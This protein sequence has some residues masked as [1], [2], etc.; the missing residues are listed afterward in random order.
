MEPQ[1]EEIPQ[2]LDLCLRQGLA[3]VESGNRSRAVQLL[4]HV[5]TRDETNIAAWYGLSQVVDSL[6][7]KEIC[8]Q[9][10]IT[11]DPDDTS[12]RRE[13][14]TTSQR[15]TEQLLQQGILQ[16]K[17][18]RIAEARETFRQVAERDPANP[19]PW[20]WL[21]SLAETPAERE[22]CLRTL[23]ELDPYNELAHR[24]LAQ[25]EA[26]KLLQ[27]PGEPSLPIM[28]PP[29]PI[30]PPE[31]PPP[32][33]VQLQLEDRPIPT[34]P[35]ELPFWDR[36]RDELL[37]PYCAK[38][39]TKMED[40]V[41][42]VCQ[43]PL[44]LKIRQR[45]YISSFYQFLII[46][47]IALTL[48]AAIASISTACG[49]GKELGLGNGCSIIP[50]YFGLPNDIPADLATRALEMTPRWIVI[51]YFLP[52]VIY[53]F[54]VIG[55]AL[56]WVP[57]Y[58]ILFGTV[59]AEVFA[60]LYIIFN[61]NHFIIPPAVLLGGLFCLILSI[62]HGWLIYSSG[63]DFFYEDHRLLLRIESGAKNPVLALERGEFFAKNK[64]WA[65]AAIYLRKAAT[66]LPDRSGPRLLLA[67]ACYKLDQRDMAIL[68]YNEAKAMNPQD[69]RLVGLQAVLYPPADGPG[70]A[71]PF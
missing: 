19:T 37:C 31:A 56:R 69:P 17:A 27:T 22:T 49:L 53:L 13:L 23:L 47:Q 6:E 18:G 34:V 24:T 51:L 39:T 8:L 42:P 63:E 41:C 16:N 65:L 45:E 14:E 50:F 52:L 21:S 67:I 61:Y 2:D 29:L 20:Q 1:S 60:S 46:I 55:V 57:T 15:Y 30:H 40:R 38:T 35:N 12:V 71:D 43:Q 28:P 11:L 7:E 68:Y 36:L 48:I 32:P 10:V 62:L 70:L 25:M 44:W 66:T 58:F 26:Q 33:P 9:N 4:T 54:T 3:A 5:V 64:L 59:I